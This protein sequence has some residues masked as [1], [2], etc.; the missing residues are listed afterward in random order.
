[1]NEDNGKRA[2]V[3]TVGKDFG[4]ETVEVTFYPYKELKS[5]W[6]KNGSKISLKISDYLLD[7]DNGLLEDYVR[8][9]FRRITEGRKIEYS[10]RI[11]NWLSSDEFLNRNRKKYLNRSRN[12]SLYTCGDYYD[13][14]ELYRDLIAQ[15]LI[16]GTRGVRITWTKRPNRRRVG[17]C[18]L[19]MKVVTVSSALDSSSIPAYVPQYVLYH[20]LLHLEMKTSSL[21][22]NHSRRFRTRE[23]EF[24]M[25]KEAEKWLKKVARS[26]GTEQNY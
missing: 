16:D 15:A 22:A 7:A 26:G 2:V 8:A 24:P 11:N 4:F 20:E 23:R 18:S 12:L 17:Y 19:L 1:M 3:R 5:K 9:L 14:E 21:S 10:D 6:M 25:W 13:L